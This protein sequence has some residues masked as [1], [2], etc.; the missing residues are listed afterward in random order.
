MAPQAQGDEILSNM[1]DRRPS[2]ERESHAS[3]TYFKEIEGNTYLVVTRREC[4][5]RTG[6]GCKLLR[7][8][9]TLV[10]DQNTQ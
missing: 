9:V 2:R 10:E 7:M 8:E 3:N 1:R 5:C 6:G 4:R